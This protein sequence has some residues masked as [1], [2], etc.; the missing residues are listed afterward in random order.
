MFLLRGGVW[1]FVTRGAR[2]PKIFTYVIYR[3]FF[4]TLTLQISIGLFSIVFDFIWYET[5]YH[6]NK[7]SRTII[8]PIACLI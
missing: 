5:Q 8:F 6:F 1:E 2:K 4:D 3:P 7:T